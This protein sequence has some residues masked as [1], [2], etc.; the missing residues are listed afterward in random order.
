VY[1]TPRERLEERVEAMKT[2]HVVSGCVFEKRLDSYDLVRLACVD[3]ESFLDV[4]R[5][6]SERIPCSVRLFLA[7]RIRNALVDMKDEESARV[8]ETTLREVGI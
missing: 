2:E 8:I 6:D 3:E 1:T 5:M 7:D 4:V